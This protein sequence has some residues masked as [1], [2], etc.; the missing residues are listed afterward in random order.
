MS[1][2]T[3]ILL[4]LLLIFIL[5]GVSYP[6]NNFRY[7][8]NAEDKF[9]KALMLFKQNK[10]SDA[11]TIFDFLLN[12]KPIH[13][14]TTAA[15]LMAGKTLYRMKQYNASVILMNE[16]LKNYP[17]TNYISDVYYLI[18]LNKLMQQHYDESV[19]NLIRCLEITDN[20]KT[21]KLASSLFE[22]LLSKQISIEHV[23]RL[24]SGI[25]R[26]DV[27]DHL[28]LMLAEKYLQEGE[29]RKAEKLLDEIIN[30][31]THSKY[32]DKARSLEK[33]LISS[34]VF[35]IGVVLSL[36][37]ENS[38]GNA[39]KKISEEL[40]QGMMIAL[41]KSRNKSEL[42]DIIHLEVL[43]DKRDSST[44]IDAVKELASMKDVL[45]IVGPLY[46]NI[47]LSCARM[48]SRYDVPL[49]VPI[50]SANGI[51]GFGENIYQANTDLRNR[52]RLMAK[53]A[54]KK[55]GFK[56]V[57]ILT[58]S[59]LN[60]RLIAESFE[61]EAKKLGGNIVSVEYYAKGSTDLSEQF[62]NIRRAGFKIIGKGM[63]SD[64]LQVP[65]RSIDGL[66]ISISDPEDIGVI[67][68]QIKYFNIET[69][70]LGNNEWYA[71]QQLEMNKNYLNGL[72]FQADSYND[73]N[74][75]IFQEFDKAYFEKQKKHPSKY[76]L[77]GYDIMH[78]L[79]D[80][81]NTGANTR[82]KL[83][84]ALSR[85]H[86]Y[87]GLHGKITFENGRVNSEIHILQ[88]LNGEIKKLSEQS[89]D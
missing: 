23:V 71:P 73:E 26:V 31:K 24:I 42:S 6:Q 75:P 17:Y 38:L 49:I 30:R 11:F 43:D 59:D 78:L 87:P 58:S 64:N 46:S 14:R 3:K 19:E 67:A 33:V 5:L 68:P 27:K 72:I 7:D 55:R 63:N 36:M 62:R 9:S 52:G 89:I 44:A 53:Y 66:F 32:L 18:A 80:K 56:N 79:I 34:R 81:I 41:E 82:D 13:Q 1:F 48:V 60:S 8:A 50:A 54:I 47:A 76:S 69:Q 88:Y 45:A 16:F 86:A 29:K 28:S 70:L 25:K 15:Y 4:L 39:S 51:A 21:Y 20:E 37:R 74:D 84:E 83:K 77:I 57:G 22:S 35:K 2:I 40:L 12:Q 65:L 85:V 10:Y 61:Q